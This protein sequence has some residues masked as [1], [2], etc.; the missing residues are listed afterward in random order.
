MIDDTLRGYQIA[1]VHR[2][3]TAEHWAVYDN[4]P[5]DVAGALMRYWRRPAWLRFGALTLE[6]ACTGAEQVVRWR[7][8]LDIRVQPQREVIA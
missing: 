1:V 8:V 3:E 6:D 7:D 4:V 5:D 2:V